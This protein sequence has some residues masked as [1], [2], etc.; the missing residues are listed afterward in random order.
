MN[1]TATTGLLWSA[2]RRSQN[3]GEAK[4]IG[5]LPLDSVGL[6]LRVYLVAEGQG[7]YFGA[8]D[9]RVW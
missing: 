2:S 7:A 9:V 3:D 1:R 6:R 8:L 5:H 4:R